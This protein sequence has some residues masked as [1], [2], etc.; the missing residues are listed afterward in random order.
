MAGLELFTMMVEN[1]PKRR[2]GRLSGVIDWRDDSAKRSFA[3]R[4]EKPALRA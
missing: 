2:I 3:E 1:P 4:A